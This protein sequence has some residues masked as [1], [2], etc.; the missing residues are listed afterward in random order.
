MPNRASVILFLLI[1][2]SFQGPSASSK[3]SVR[4]EQITQGPQSSLRRV[5]RARAESSVEQERTAHRH[6]LW[7]RDGDRIYFHVR[8]DFETRGRI[9][10]PMTIN[11]DGSRF[12]IH[13]TWIMSGAKP[14][15]Q[16]RSSE[17]MKSMITGSLTHAMGT[18]ISANH[19]LTSIEG[20]PEN[21]AEYKVLWPVRSSS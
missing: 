5:Y 12:A 15:T 3:L 17:P 11:S 6:T 16:S 10:I 14:P 9:N 8:A 18:A 1:V 21:N 4:I 2:F 19:G 20:L 7:N 13:K